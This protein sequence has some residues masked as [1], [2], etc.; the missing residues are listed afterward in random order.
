MIN[1]FLKYLEYERRYSKHTVTSYRNDLKQFRSFSLNNFDADLKDANHGILRAWIVELSES[2]IQP[3]SINR[4]MA[5]L[6]SYYKYLLKHDHIAKDPTW[7][8]KTLKTPRRIPH[9]VDE[10]EMNTLLDN[11]E[12]IASHT[13]KR[14]S[15]IIELLY[16][17]GVR[18]SELINI[19]HGDINNHQHT[20][21]VLGK[22]NKE[23][24][25][26]FSK[27]LH[28]VIEEY[29]VMKK[30][31]IAAAEHDYLLVTDGGKQLY[32]MFVQRLTK[33]YFA[34][35]NIDKKSPHVLRHTYATHMLNNGAELNAVKELL[36]HTSLAATQVYTHN[37]MEKLK[38]VFDQAHPKA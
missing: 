1:S 27:N 11:R 7:K 23:R 10:G 31:E 37:T 34:N 36:G 12:I 5:S 9:F 32:P 4:K 26:P 25:I 22:R 21:K 38:K 8:L 3:T 35:T 29:V 18:L 17:T 6:R 2:K 24:I 30:K 16:G 20:I 19:K 33:R 13:T 15:L 28:Q 14:D